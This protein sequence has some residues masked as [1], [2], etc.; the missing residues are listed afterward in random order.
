MYV[1]TVSSVRL[2]PPPPEV[3]FSLYLMRFQLAPVIGFLV[4][5]P[6]MTKTLNTFQKFPD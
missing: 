6:L 3:S 2:Q 4:L 5:S 1:L